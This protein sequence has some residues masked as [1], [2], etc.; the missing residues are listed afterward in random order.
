MDGSIVGYARGAW[1]EEAGGT[2]VLEVICFLRPEWCRRG[3]GT[4]MLATIEARIWEVDAGL[5]A[6][7]LHVFQAE[8]AGG[9]AGR[10]ALLHRTGYVPVRYSFQIIR[11]TLDDQPDAP[12]PEGLEIRDVRPEHMRAI[13]EAEQEAFG[14]HWGWTPGTDETYLQFLNDP[15]QGDTSLWRVAWDSDE[16]AGMVRGFINHEANA[17][18]GQLRGWVEDISVRRPWRHRGLARALMAA[19][20][21][22][23]RARGVTEGALGVD[24]ENPTGALRVYESVGFRPVKGDTTYRK[25]LERLA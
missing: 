14:D 2:R 10:E 20:F 8:A 5:P 3:I 25:P 6:A 24:L 12:L 18:L 9:A 22:L 23:L 4:A 21:P 16:V 17:R 7:E 11:P 19:S 13:W 15:L 1:G